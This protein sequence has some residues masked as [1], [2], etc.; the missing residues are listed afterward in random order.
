M[1]GRRPWSAHGSERQRARR[2]LLA[3]PICVVRGASRPIRAR[4]VKEVKTIPVP[5]RLCQPIKMVS[6]SFSTAESSWFGAVSRHQSVAI[7]ADEPPSVLPA[8]C[9]TSLSLPNHADDSVCNNAP[10]S[11]GAVVTCRTT[12]ID[13]ALLPSPP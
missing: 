3:T 8:S 9:P 12:A 13:S 4:I 1:G 7:S 6:L 10:S 5:G 2:F 11:P